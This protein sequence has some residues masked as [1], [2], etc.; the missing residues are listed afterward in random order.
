MTRR[1]VAG[2]GSALV[3]GLLVGIASRLLMRLTTLAAGGSAGF[4]WSGSIGIVVVY[5]GAMI[6]GALLVAATGRRGSWWLLA[7]GAAFLC[8]PAIGVASEEVGYLDDL[9][10]MRLLGVGVSGAAV[11]AT[12]AFLPVLTLRL[13]RLST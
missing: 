1:L 12:L 4:S 10:A 5:V 8:P 13:V 7:A 9:S 2:L 11:F 6:P 3:A